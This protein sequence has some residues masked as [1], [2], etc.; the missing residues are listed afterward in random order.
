MKISGVRSGIYRGRLARPVEFEHV[1]DAEPGSG[2]RVED[3]GSR[4]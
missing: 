1:P 4:V 2:F 3:L